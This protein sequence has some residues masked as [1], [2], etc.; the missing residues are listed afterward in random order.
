LDEGLNSD[1]ISSVYISTIIGWLDHLY[2][3]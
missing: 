3:G 2:S 1:E